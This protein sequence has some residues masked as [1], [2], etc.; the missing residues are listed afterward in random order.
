M[1]SKCTTESQSQGR[2]FRR[3]L[4]SVA[5]LVAQTVNSLPTM[6]EAHV[7]HQGWGDLEKGMAT[8]SSSLSW[9]ISWS[10]E[11]ARPQSTGS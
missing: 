6:V 2:E 9:R 7:Q 10:A 1:P 4:I 3:V 11:P 5:S 8:H